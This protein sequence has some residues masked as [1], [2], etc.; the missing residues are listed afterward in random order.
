MKILITGM[1]G[2]IG[3]AL[4]A[5]LQAKG[6]QVIGLGL[7]PPPE[8]ALARLGDLAFFDV[9]V[10]DRA[11]LG[12]IVSSS[13]PDVIVHAAAITPD[14]VREASGDVARVVAV[15][16]GGSTNVIEVAAAAK[17]RRVVH[18]SSV[19]VYGR[20]IAEVPRLDEEDTICAPATLYALTK[21]AAERLAL[22]MGAV[23][24]VE[25]I[26]PRLGIAWGPWEYRTGARPLPSP[27]YQIMA[28]AR[29]G[30][31]AE[32]T[33]GTLTPLVYVEEAT[34][35]LARLITAPLPP[36]GVVNLGASTLTDLAD[37]ARWIGRF[38]GA[39]RAGGAVAMLAP[40]RPPMDGTRLTGLT[41]MDPG[42]ATE[43]QLADWCA[44]IAGLPD[45][46]A[47]FV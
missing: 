19:A 6:A 28:L 43:S 29:R 3:L 16:V 25:V 12:A 44:W 9:D 14:A 15:N 41:S 30:L 17:V 11:A 1:G 32:V 22:R 36:G 10:T 42:A 37:L 33:P 40:N 2:F 18:L 8:W 21:H 34:E 20:S 26:S 5:R 24:G 35:A 47:P 23:L 27:P 4:A 39:E 7:E 13:R 38:T 45:P 46:E 31:T